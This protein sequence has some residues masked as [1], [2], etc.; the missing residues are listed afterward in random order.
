MKRSRLGRVGRG[1]RPRGSEGDNLQS[2]YVGTIAFMM[3]IHAKT[4]GMRGEGEGEIQ[5]VKVETEISTGLWV[6]GGAEWRCQ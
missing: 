3:G 4:K 5:S 6:E 1:G 2:V